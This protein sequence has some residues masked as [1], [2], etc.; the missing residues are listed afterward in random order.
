MAIR[1]QG[2]YETSDFW[3]EVRDIGNSKLAELGLSDWSVT[4]RPATAS[5]AEHASRGGLLLAWLPHARRKSAN[6]TNTSRRTRKPIPGRQYGVCAGLRPPGIR[7][8]R[9]AH[10]SRRSV[11]LWHSEEWLELSCACLIER[12]HSWPRVGR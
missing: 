1:L 8:A 12:A 7:N 2:G 6:A 11:T 9:S 4:V 10:T 5:D 3:R